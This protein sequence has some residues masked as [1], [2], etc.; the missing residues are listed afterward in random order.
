MAVQRRFAAAMMMMKKRNPDVT[1]VSEAI[2]S[3]LLL[4]HETL[5]GTSTSS[6]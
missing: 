6:S 4:D 1:E 2:S 3:V 5:S